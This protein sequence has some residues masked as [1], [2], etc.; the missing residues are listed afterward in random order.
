MDEAAGTVNERVTARWDSLTPSERIVAAYMREH[1]DKI[2]TLSSEELGA[3]TN[4]SD[5]T[6]IRTSKSLGYKGFKDLRQAQLESLMRG[7]DPAAL[8]K[9]RIGSMLQ[10]YEDCDRVL[11]D[12]IQLLQ[13]LRTH[14][15]QEAWNHAVQLVSESRRVFSFGLGPLA[16][17][18]EYLTLMLG[19]IGID[20]SGFTNSGF[21][22]ADDL[23][24]VHEGDVVIVFAALR[25]FQEI[26]VLVEH[27]ARTRASV[28]LVT[29]ALGMAFQ[30][31]A[32]VIISTPQ[33]TT[34]TASE[35]APGLILCHAMVLS[36][37]ARANN[38]SVNHMQRLNQLRGDIVKS[39]LD[40]RPIYVPAELPSEQRSVSTRECTT[41]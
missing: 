38:R 8:L 9:H 27:A 4:T 19:R 24:R 21:R 25:P 11:A 22:L 29:E 17:L 14:L 40:V 35:V 7:R 26:E 39:D 37:A 5:A 1:P 32:D 16:V 23:L 34:T 33:S 15:D 31:R 36:L 12:S 3:R 6:V 41:D 28:V 2:V 30:G 13:D 20:A 18:A 10:G